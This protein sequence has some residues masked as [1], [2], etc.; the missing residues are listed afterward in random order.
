MEVFLAFSR[1]YNVYLTTEMKHEVSK[2]HLMV[3]ETVIL[4]LQRAISFDN[5]YRNYFSNNL[6]LYQYMGFSVSLLTYYRTHIF[7]DTLGLS[8][9]IL[10]CLSTINLIMNGNKLNNAHLL[11]FETFVN[12]F[13]VTSRIRIPPSIF[14]E[15]T[16]WYFQVLSNE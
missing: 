2:W 16:I 10:D 11:D 15:N 8:F 1:F 14:T 6:F 4:I 9:F 12:H 5:Q 3:L 7:E 13:C